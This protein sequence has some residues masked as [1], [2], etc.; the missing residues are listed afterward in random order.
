[1]GE[2]SH[3]S[4]AGRGISVCFLGWSKLDFEAGL[5]VSLPEFYRRE[6]AFIGG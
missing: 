3:P 2:G 6:V 4:R 1:M 5:T